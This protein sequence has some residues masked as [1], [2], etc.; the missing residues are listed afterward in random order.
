MSRH[1]GKWEAEP[2]LDISNDEQQELD[3]IA[4]FEHLEYK[5]DLLHEMW[6]EG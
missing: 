2:E 6:K 1:F 4:E 5:A 3:D